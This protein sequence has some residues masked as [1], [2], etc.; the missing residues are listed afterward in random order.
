MAS[1]SQRIGITDIYIR[2]SR[3]SVNKREIWEK[4]V[5]YGLNNLGF[6]TSKAAP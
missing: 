6:G 4:V 3:P 5:P 2:Y 1:V